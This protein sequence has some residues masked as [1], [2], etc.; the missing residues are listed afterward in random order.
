MCKKLKFYLVVCVSTEMDSVVIEESICVGKQNAALIH[1]ERAKIT[2]TR[3]LHHMGRWRWSERIRKS[4]ESKSATQH[5]IKSTSAITPHMPLLTNTICTTAHASKYTAK[6]QRYIKLCWQERH[7]TPH[8]MKGT[9][10][11]IPSPGKPTQV[12]R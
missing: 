3:I 11:Q 12:P 7:I 9:A 1:R 6:L 10:R 5:I 2:V 4:V 8:M